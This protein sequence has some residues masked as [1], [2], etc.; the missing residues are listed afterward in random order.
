MRSLVIWLSCILGCLLHIKATHF[1]SLV[2]FSLTGLKTQ[3]SYDKQ[4]YELHL[5]A[6]S[7]ITTKVELIFVV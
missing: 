1:T 4:D 5:D 6:K 3:K 2:I 7:T